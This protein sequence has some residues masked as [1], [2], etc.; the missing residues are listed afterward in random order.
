[1][2]HEFT[3]PGGST[4][5][6]TPSNRADAPAGNSAGSSSE[7]L[8]RG[9]GGSARAADGAPRSMFTAGPRVAL[10]AWLAIAAGVTLLIGISW[11]AALAVGDDTLS[12]AKVGETGPLSAVQVVP[13]MCLSEIGADGNVQDTE[14][15]RCDQPHHAEIFTQLNFALAK[16]PGV[17]EVNAQALEYCGERLP[18]VLPDDASWV[19]WTPSEQSWARGDR[20]ALCIAVFDEPKSEPV[21]PRGIDGVSTKDRNHDSQDA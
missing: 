2:T 16:H 5:H 6:S 1:M 8:T 3:P 11:S 13:G 9:R 15:V 7:G 4:S 18:G 19:V 10:A 20:V 17:D 21:S 14:V 12:L